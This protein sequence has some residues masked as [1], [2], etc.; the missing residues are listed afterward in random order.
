M[1]HV[2]IVDSQNDGFGQN[3]ARKLDVILGYQFVGVNHFF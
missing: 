1:T 2:F 3:L